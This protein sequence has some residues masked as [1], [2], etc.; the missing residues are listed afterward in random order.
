MTSQ[1]GS[2]QLG[3]TYCSI[4]QEVKAMKLGQLIGY[5]MR[6]IFLGNSHTKYGG[7]VIPRLFYKNSKL[8]ISL[9]QWSKILQFVC[10]LC[11]VVGYGNILK[12][13]CRPLA[14]NSY[15]AFLKIKKRSETSLLAS[16][17]AWFLEKNISLVITEQISLCGWLYLVRC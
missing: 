2:K 6:N 9:D 16:F 15:N 13:S 10:I 17:S 5:N 3:N 12:L 1:P 7:E 14:F 8:S 11:Q 4:S